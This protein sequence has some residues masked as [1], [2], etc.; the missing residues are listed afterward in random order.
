LDARRPHVYE[1]LQAD[2]SL[3]AALLPGCR[4]SICDLNWREPKFVFPLD[5]LRD[6]PSVL[7]RIAK[8]LMA[9][10]RCLRC[11]AM[12]ICGGPSENDRSLRGS[13]A[14]DPEMC[15]FFERAVELAVWDTV[16]LQ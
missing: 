8:D 15:E 4:V 7:T 12:A 3:V 14:P 11:P 16:G 10:E 5:V 9:D 13:D 2:G 1:H 6:T